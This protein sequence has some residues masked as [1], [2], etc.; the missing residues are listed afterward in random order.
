MW[1]PHLYWWRNWG[2]WCLNQAFYACQI[3]WPWCL[4]PGWL[5]KNLILQVF[6]A[7]PWDKALIK[8]VVCPFIQ[9]LLE[10]VDT[11]KG[12]KITLKHCGMWHNIE[13]VNVVLGRLR[14]RWT[15]VNRNKHSHCSYPR[16]HQI[17]SCFFLSY[18]AII[19]LS[20][21]FF[22]TRKWNFCQLGENNNNNWVVVSLSLRPTY[23]AK[24][25]IKRP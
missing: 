17:V 19:K 2:F 6:F 11:Q 10:I 7:F 25:G 21:I 13:C 18:N 24:E 1:L 16:I 12:T 4:L 8:Q 15:H 22:H 9:Y 20:A 14:P 23:W 3:P 5:S